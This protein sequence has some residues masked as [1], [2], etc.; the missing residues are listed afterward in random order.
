MCIIDDQGIGT[1]IGTGIG[2]WVYGIKAECET[3][4]DYL[5][6][7]YHN[8]G[9][10]F[11]CRKEHYIKLVRASTESPFRYHPIQYLYGSNRYVSK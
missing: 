11:S 3:H 9:L 7:R 5:V 10:Y 2:G 6:S 4:H 1:G 8:P